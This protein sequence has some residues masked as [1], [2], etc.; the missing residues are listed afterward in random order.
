M[1]SIICAASCAVNGGKTPDGESVSEEEGTPVSILPVLDWGAAR[2]KMMHAHEGELT[3]TV[4]SDTLLRYT[5]NTGDVTVDYK[6]DSDRLVCSSLTQRNLSS[7]EE[8]AYSWLSGYERIMLSENTLLCIDSENTTLAYGRLLRGND[9]SYVSVA[10]TYVDPEEEMP[11]GPD[12]SASGTE[13]GYDYVDLGTGIGW[14][15]Q[16]VM[17]SSPADPGSYY[18]WGETWAR[19]SCWWWDYSLYHGSMQYLDEDGFSTPYQDISG[20]EYDAASKNMGGRWRMPTR[21]EMY[22]LVNNCIFEVGEFDGTKGFIVTGP[23]GKSI[24]LPVTGRK[25]HDE[26]ELTNTIFL[27]SSSVSG[28]R[29]AYYLNYMTMNPDASGVKTIDRYYG[30]PVRAVIDLQ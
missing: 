23:S 18:L 4:S 12:Y 21:A 8:A 14:A 10:W 17:A 7:V 2:E 9:C 15:V 16:N 24:F 28:Q 19:S 29:N 30:L 11:D 27:W 5:D 1:L 26:V 6:F 20:T 13:N 3:L 22:S 25:K